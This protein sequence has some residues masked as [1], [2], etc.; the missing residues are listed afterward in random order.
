MRMAVLV[1]VAMVGVLVLRTNSAVPCCDTSNLAFV[2][3]CAHVFCISSFTYL[4]QH[5]HQRKSNDGDKKMKIAIIIKR[6]E[7]DKS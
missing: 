6:R 3:M 4:L 2:G 1:V 7:S 5:A